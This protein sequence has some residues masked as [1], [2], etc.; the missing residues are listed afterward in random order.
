MG[1]SNSFL[2]CVADIC[3]EELTTLINNYKYSVY[4]GN[5]LVVEG[6]KGISEYG[7]KCVSFALPK[8]VLTVT[9]DDLRIKYLEKNFAV[10]VGSI[11]SVEVSY[12]KQM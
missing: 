5:T 1:M 8:S 11:R 12:E 4:G 10:V 2:Q 9:G 3:G 7:S 6:H